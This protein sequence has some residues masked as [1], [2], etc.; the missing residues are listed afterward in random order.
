MLLSQLIITLSNLMAIR[1]I[2]A[3][4]DRT[5]QVILTF[6]MISSIL[7]HLGENESVNTKPF[8]KNRPAHH[9]L[10][11]IKP[12][13][14]YAVTLLQFDRIGALLAMASVVPLFII[15]MK[16]KDTI[17]WIKGLASLTCLAASEIYPA[18]PLLFTVGHSLWHILAFE[19][20]YHII[21]A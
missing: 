8:L 12:F 5:I 7:Y 1:P 19:T 21:N 15:K 3:T 16:Y 10:K 13:R 2:M 14:D 9:K 17:F 20:A 6:S 18:G 11:G 4:T